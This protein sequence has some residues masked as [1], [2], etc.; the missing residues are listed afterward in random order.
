MSQRA[1]L[2]VVVVGWLLLFGPILVQGHVIAAHDN[3]LELGLAAASDGKVAAASSRKLADHSAIFIPAL[4]Q[5]LR[6]DAEGWL[7]TW[8][9]HT[10]LGRPAAHVS[11]FS[12]AFPILR[13]ISWFTDDPYVAYTALVALATLLG[14]GFAFG[15]FR[16]LDLHPAA[17]AFGALLLGVGVFSAFWLTFAMLVWG[18]CWSTGVLWAVA[19]FVRAPGM[20]SAIAIS[21]CTYALLLSGYPQQIVW[22]AY[23]ITGFAAWR[24]LRTAS[25][26]TRRGALALG[27]AAAALA[28][29]LATA[30]VY[31][32]L[33]LTTQASARPSA[34]TAFFLG[35]LPRMSGVSDFAVFVGLLIDAFWFG[36]PIRDAY[37]TAFSGPSLTPLP[38]CLAGLSLLG[39]LRRRLWPVQL[40]VVATL[41]ATLVPPVF[42][43][44]VEFFGFGLSRFLPLAAGVLPWAV[45]ATYAADHVLRVGVAPRTA[46]IAVGVPAA[47]A[48]LAAAGSGLR[49]DALAVACSAS[50]FA[51]SWVFLATRNA[52]LL[53]GV[54]LASVVYYG[55]SLA[56]S[57][58][59]GDLAR[60][61]PVVETL[62]RETR[63]GSRFAK[64]GHE[65]GL[66]VPS[67][68][69][70]VVGLRSVHAYDSLSPAAY[71][72]WAE[73]V[74]RGGTRDGGRFFRNL[75]DA[76]RIDSPAFA[77]AGVSVVAASRPLDAAAVGP[78]V[79]E[80][81][82]VHFHRT[83][84]PLLLEA[85]A[86]IREA[87]GAAASAGV[88]LSVSDAKL[89]ASAVRRR[90]DRDDRLQFE[91]P[92]D[93]AHERLL[94]VSQQFHPHWIASAGAR[95]LEARVVNDFYQGV[96]VPPGVGAVE[97][98]F[99][100]WARFSG[101]PHLGF[102]I[103]GAALVVRW[104]AGRRSGERAGRRKWRSPH[105]EPPTN[106]GPTNGSDR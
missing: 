15:L 104:L 66:L 87:P 55:G 47:I 92:A 68:Q 95:P 5:H 32:D 102:A 16:E 35:A 4:H 2:A 84:G 62:E 26:A 106:E 90:I 36:N 18:V 75:A 72:R 50:L 56:L 31:A 67:N 98:R 97:L 45:L 80:R 77:L 57:L 86:A 34:D 74:S 79:A 96:V 11:G 85:I 94:F 21:F 60:T 28:G 43:I 51:G 19:R 25:A 76:A 41:V 17:A 3:R 29:A 70:G 44:A 93:A 9:P 38:L 7:S 58:A 54:A 12:K 103:A 83:H 88:G 24:L 65:L 27:L 40:F 14:C 91:F 8:N 1:A 53:C 33:W 64:V 59:P 20:G 39:V 99:V 37:P 10:Q 101:I 81:A 71:Q 105:S 100:P 63:G 6:G 49:V 42:A 46:A 89:G 73:R 69:E 61:S 30:P 23:A 52:R 48:A 13:V 82:G 22:H 78:V